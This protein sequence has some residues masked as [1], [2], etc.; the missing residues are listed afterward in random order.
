MIVDLSDT[1]TGIDIRTQGQN[2]IVDFVKTSLPEN[3]RRRLDVID[4]CTPVNA[5]NTF[6]QGENVRMVIEPK[7]TGSTTP[8]SPIP[9]SWSR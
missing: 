7:G 8:T 2:I 5:V 3:L 6:Q 1:R 4:F 9:S